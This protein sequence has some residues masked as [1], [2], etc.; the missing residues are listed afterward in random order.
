MLL[1]I[2]NVKRISTIR[3]SLDV[4]LF[5]VSLKFEFLLQ[6]LKSS[7]L[8]LFLNYVIIRNEY[9]DKTYIFPSH[10]YFGEGYEDSSSSQLIFGTTLPRP[11]ENSNGSTLNEAADQLYSTFIQ[12]SLLKMP[13]K[14]EQKQ[15]ALRYFLAKF[16]WNV[17]FIT[18][19]F[20]S[21]LYT[22]LISIDSLCSLGLVGKTN[23]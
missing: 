7:D 6:N 18:N 5:L 14:N 2:P 3:F 21:V 17:N 19:Y 23:S 10:K 11:P 20:K 22:R 16:I 12:N 13:S 15:T 8:S 1:R 4:I 9:A